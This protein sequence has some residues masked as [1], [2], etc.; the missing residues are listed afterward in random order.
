MGLKLMPPFQGLNVS[1]CILMG[2]RPMFT[3]SA[4]SGLMYF[5]I[6]SHRV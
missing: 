5:E 6:T 3:D 4:P 2:L 1:W